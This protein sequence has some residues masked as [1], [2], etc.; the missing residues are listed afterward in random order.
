MIIWSNSILFTDDIAIFVLYQGIPYDMRQ[1]A[2]DMQINKK[3]MIDATG[4]RMMMRCY[5]VRDRKILFVQTTQMSCGMEAGPTFSFAIT[6]VFCSSLNDGR[7]KPCHLTTDLRHWDEKSPLYCRARV[8]G[9][10][11]SMWPSFISAEKG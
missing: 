8:P 11:L 7:R 4:D 6:P 3:L 5:F 2:N 9:H 10:I 1:H